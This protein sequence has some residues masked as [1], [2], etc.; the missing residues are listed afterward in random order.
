MRERS[1]SC[2]APLD[3]FSAFDSKEGPLY[4]PAAPQ[5]RIPRKVVKA[6]IG[7]LGLF[8]LAAAVWLGLCCC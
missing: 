8:G 4:D 7:L 2:E 6:G 3:G 1:I 5:F